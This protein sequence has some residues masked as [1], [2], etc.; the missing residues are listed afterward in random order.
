MSDINRLSSRSDDTT[1]DLITDEGSHEL[2]AEDA[3][4]R[5]EW[6][7]ITLTLSCMCTRTPKLIVESCMIFVD[8]CH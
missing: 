8:E 7:R 5:E 2:S 4:E 6:V 3:A 1:F